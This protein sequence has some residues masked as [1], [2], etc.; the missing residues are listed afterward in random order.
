MKYK[1]LP[2][3]ELEKLE[4]EF[5]H[6]LAVNSITAEDYKK[7]QETDRAKIIELIETFSDMVY[8]RVMQKITY[9]DHRTSDEIKVFEAGENKISLLGIKSKNKAI[10]FLKEDA[11]KSLMN[12]TIQDD[13]EIYKSEKPYNKQRE[14]EVFEMLEQGCCVVDQSLYEFLDKIYANT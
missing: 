1:I 6:F 7:M 14:I 11:F 12:G 5:I 8:E 9:I 10:D 3:E 4:K 2:Q 13:F